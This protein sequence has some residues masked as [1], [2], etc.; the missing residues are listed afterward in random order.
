MD[1]YRITGIENNL[2]I[3]ITLLDKDMLK[4]SLQTQKLREVGFLR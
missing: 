2:V 1:I 4:I 3:F